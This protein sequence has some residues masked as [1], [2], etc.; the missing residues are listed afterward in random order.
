MLE[1]HKNTEKKFHS[2]IMKEFS[3]L[4]GDAKLLSEEDKT[5]LVNEVTEYLIM[6]MPKIKIKEALIYI[7]DNRALIAR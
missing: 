1:P 2:D 5:I 3:D 4:G 6:T 7:R